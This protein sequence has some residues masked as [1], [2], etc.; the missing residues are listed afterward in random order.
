MNTWQRLFSSK[1]YKHFLRNRLATDEAFPITQ[2]AMAK[3]AGCKASY[4]SQCLNGKVHLLPEQLHAIGVFLKMTEDEIE[5]LL[6]LLQYERSGSAAH[7][8]FVRRR[9]S[10]LKE[11][12]ERISYRLQRENRPS[13]TKSSDLTLYYNDWYMTAVH[14]LCTLPNIRTAEDVALKL[15]LT[16]SE[17]QRAVKVLQ[18]LELIFEKDGKLI[19][20]S[21]HIHVGDQDPMIS[22]HH[23]NWRMRAA[24]RTQPAPNSDLHY[25]AVYSLSRRDALAIREELAQTLLKVREKVKPSPEEC[26]VAFGVDWFRLDEASVKEY[27]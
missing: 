11:D 5:Y 9:I 25:S 20:T 26:V 16:R 12:R 7:R 13:S 2:A 10:E 8:N 15:G 21:H 1:D 23:A 18:Q 4:L 17:A 3:A 14:I 24:L 19:A 27:P 6:L 22:R